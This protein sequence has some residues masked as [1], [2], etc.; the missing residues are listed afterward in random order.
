MKKIKPIELHT[1][2]LDIRIPKYEDQYDLWNI[3]KQEKVN[4]YYQSTP[5]RFKTRKE[6]QEALQ[7]WESQK[8]YYY[9][10][11][12][13]LDKDSDMYSW[14]IFLKDTDKPIGQIT[15]QPNDKYNDLN[16]RNIGWYINPELQGKGLAYEAAFEV[17]KFMFNKVEIERI[18][19][20]AVIQNPSSWKLMQKL[21]FIRTGTIKAS[22]KDMEEKDIYKYTYLLT[23]E[24]FLEKLYELEKANNHNKFKK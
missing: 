7:D 20:E 2:N 17:L 15:V 14:T 9:L 6:Y 12:K 10:K 16:I 8:K 19:T 23:K 1:N 3:Q 5:S 21:G 4:I 24:M 22:Y 13:N 11:I 18:E